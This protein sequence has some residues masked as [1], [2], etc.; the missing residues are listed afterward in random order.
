MPGL[1]RQLAAASRRIVGPALL[2]P[3]LL[4]LLVT[5]G[6]VT[7][8]AGGEAFIHVPLDHVFAAQEFPLVAADLGAGADVV[9]T[10]TVDQQVTPLGTFR[11]GDDGHFDATLMLPAGYPDG[12]TLLTAASS[13][14]STA[15]TWVLVGERTTTTPPA[16]D[17]VEWWQDSSTL[18]IIVPIAL[19]V[20]ALGY[21]AF[22]AIS[23][24]RS[25]RTG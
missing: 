20:G 4:G 2:G 9:V 23:S 21:L 14:G 19:L 3:A 12:Y 25:R 17:Q 13:D 1:G 15:Q 11:A 5:P 10:A 24:V 6:S 7:A 16:P 22:R 8:H 18:G